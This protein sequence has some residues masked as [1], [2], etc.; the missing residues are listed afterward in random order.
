MIAII[1]YIE[2]G[3]IHIAAG[4]MTLT[5]LAG[6]ALFAGPAA[7]GTVNIALM[8]AMTADEQKAFTDTT[9]PKL[10]HRLMIQHGE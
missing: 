1:C 10:A 9:Y 3:L 6:N 7:V 8:S 5:P 4:L 2:W